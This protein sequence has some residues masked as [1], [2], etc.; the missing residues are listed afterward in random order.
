MLSRNLFPEFVSN[1]QC[2][3]SWK[4]ECNSFNF[5]VEN[6]KDSNGMFLLL[7]RKILSV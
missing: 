4:Q 3:S 5:S 6:D 7:S 1:E 2:Y